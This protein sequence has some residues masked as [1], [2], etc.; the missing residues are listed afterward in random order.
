[1][2]NQRR[3]T[4]AIV[5]TIL[6]LMIFFTTMLLGLVTVAEANL[7]R[8]RGRIML[9][10]A[11]YAAESGADAAIATLNSGTTT[12][13]GTVSDT[14]VLSTG[15]YK[16]TYAVT[17]ANG[18]TSKERFITATGKVY[19]PSTKTAPNYTRKI[20]VTAQRSS[21]TTASSVM[22][23]NI[24]DI[25]SSVKTIMGRDIYVNGYINMA[26]NTTDLIAENITAA[27]KNTGATNCSIGGSGNLVK[28]TSFTNP[29]QTKTVLN[30]AFNNCITPPGNTSNTDFTVNA[31]INTVSQIQS[32][33]IPW[34]QYMDN[35]Y[36]SSPGGCSD[37]TSGGTTRQIPSTG[38]TKKTH[39]PDSSSGIA[40]SCGTSGDLDLGSNTYVINDNVHI[41]ANLCAASGCSPIF[42]NPTAGTVRY[43]FVEGTANFNSLQTSSGSGPIVLITYGTDPASKASVC[44]DGGSLYLG[45]SGNTSASAMYLLATNGLCLDKTKFGSSPALGG[46]AGK[47]LYISTNSGTPFDLSMDPNFPVSQIPIDL[48]WREVYYERL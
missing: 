46:I 15:G 31:N 37:W 4:G 39:Y 5:V 44:P 23:R 32:T 29:G 6:M 13:T 9:L 22:S 47:N 45:N 35:T 48:A 1:M 38:N 27:G 17:V 14:S 18:A 41:R 33:Y 21:T 25:G 7:S 12:Y 2:R 43:I 42:N 16:A 34:S 30:L 19:D 8:A 11:Q 10:Q 24:L 3:E 36:Q 20:R 28:P 26:K 40:T